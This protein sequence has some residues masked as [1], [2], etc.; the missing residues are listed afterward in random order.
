MRSYDD[1]DTPTVTS[2]N[3][4]DEYSISSRKENKYMTLA[5]PH[6]KKISNEKHYNSR[7]FNTKSDFSLTT[8]DS[9]FFIDGS[10]NYSLSRNHK[11]DSRAEKEFETDDLINYFNYIKRHDNL[12]DYFID[13][14]KLKSNNYKPQIKSRTL[15]S[16]E[17]CE[18]PNQLENPTPS[19]PMSLE[20]NLVNEEG[21]F[22]DQVD[23]TNS[24]DSYSE[25]KEFY[26]NRKNKI[27]CHQLLPHS[28]KDDEK[29]KIK[30]TA[31]MRMKKYH[32]DTHK[33]VTFKKRKC[34]YTI[35]FYFKIIR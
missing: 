18:Y 7:Y 6:P 1:L 28:K 21:S 29:Y 23:D 26:M 9:S 35:Y 32:T 27:E 12:S 4:S 17:L 14:T 5:T 19:F 30:M 34:K 10:G 11:F 25:T 2:I 13:F 24:Y 22:Y 33:F 31:N 15:K 16:T 20:D 3:M 8:R